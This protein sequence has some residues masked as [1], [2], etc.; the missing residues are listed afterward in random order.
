MYNLRDY[1]VCDGQIFWD[2]YVHLRP[3]VG[4]WPLS[5]HR[6]ERRFLYQCIDSWHKWDMSVRNLQ[7]AQ[8]SYIGN[9]AFCRLVSSR[10]V[11]LREKG[12]KTAWQSVEFPKR[13]Q[14]MCEREKERKFEY[15]KNR[16]ITFCIPFSPYL[17]AKLSSV[18]KP[19]IPTGGSYMYNDCVIHVQG[20][21]RRKK[22]CLCRSVIESS[23]TQNAGDP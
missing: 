14:R 19:T 2:L 20:F 15:A 4:P 23:E 17:D 9:S 22:V 10:L 7:A 16:G 3:L 18:F 5:S 13:F 6:Y 8:L 1:F 11:L 12:T 21:V